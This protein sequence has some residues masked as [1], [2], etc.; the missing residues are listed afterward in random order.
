MCTNLN[1]KLNTISERM[2]RK[3]RKERLKSA[4]QLDRRSHNKTISNL[5]K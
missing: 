3:L 5:K 2:R 4:V 1:K